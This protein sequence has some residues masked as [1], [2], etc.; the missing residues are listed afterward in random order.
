MRKSLKMK[1]V[2][3]VIKKKFMRLLYKGNPIGY[4]RWLGVR[5]GDNCK[6]HA[7]PNA[8]FSTEPFLISIGNHVL[9]TNGVRF[10][11]HDGSAFTLAFNKKNAY[12]D[13]WGPIHIG[14][15]VYI[16]TNTIILP[17]VSVCDNVIIAA[18]SVVS[19]NITQDG[20]YAGVPVRRI[21]S[22]SEYCESVQTKVMDN[23]GLSFEQRKMKY[24]SVNPEWFR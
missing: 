20:V 17:N 13:I 3:S 7:D 15:N 21:K 11:T 4:A 24:E 1:A 19:K 8:C 18:G 22:F 10:L 5:I 16:G 14:N 12:F 2:I 9:I 23:Y 6:I